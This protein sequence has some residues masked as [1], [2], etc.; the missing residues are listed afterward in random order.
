MNALRKPARISILVLYALLALPVLPILGMTVKALFWLVPIDM[1]VRAVPLYLTF[2]LDRQFGDGGEVTAEWMPFWV[3]GTAVMLWPMIALGVRPGWWQF[4]AMRRAVA[5]YSASAFAVT[6]A[7][8][9]WVF[10]HM[11][12]FF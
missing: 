1:F 11:G 5:G 12:V 4:R 8:A 6:C 3:I 9:Y 7:S 2:L 10:T